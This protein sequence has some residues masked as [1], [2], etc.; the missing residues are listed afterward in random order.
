MPEWKLRHHR[1]SV[2]V[3]GCDDVGAAVAC[4]LHRAGAAVVV[5]DAADPP[6][7]RRVRSYTDAWYVGGAR[8]RASRRGSAAQYAPCTIAAAGLRSSGRRRLPDPLRRVSA[9]GLHGLCRLA[10]RR[11]AL[12]AREWHMKSI[13]LPV[14]FIGAVAATRAMLGLG[15]G[16]LLARSL[17]DRRRTT[18]GWA[19]L[20][21]GVLSTLPLA[22]HVISRWRDS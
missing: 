22:A 1:R 5:V 17:S 12:P 7:A 2:I 9:F 11:Q 10:G 13:A 14:P 15:A 21:V 19:L 8:P 6:W 18:V 20:A 4:V 16:L 3:I